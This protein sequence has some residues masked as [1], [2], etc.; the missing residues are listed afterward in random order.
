MQDCFRAHPEIYAS[1]LEDEEAEME[2]EL[3]EREASGTATATAP[4]TSSAPATAP[5][6]PPAPEEITQDA[7]TSEA[8][9]TLEEKVHQHPSN[10]VEGVSKDKDSDDAQSKSKGTPK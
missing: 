4:A 2:E 3:R 7:L 6:T 9:P 5:A 10:V 1:E 8:T